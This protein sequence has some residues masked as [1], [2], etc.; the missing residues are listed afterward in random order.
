MVWDTVLEVI[1]TVKAMASR[2]PELKE[3]FEELLKEAQEFDVQVGYHRRL[4][5]LYLQFSHM[6]NLVTAFM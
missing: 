2:F 5:T 1:E 6:L 3:Q 4:R